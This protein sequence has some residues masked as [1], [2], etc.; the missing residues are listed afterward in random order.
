MDVQDIILY[1]IILYYIIL[2][3]IC[4]YII[5]N[6]MGVIQNYSTRKLPLRNAFA[7]LSHPFAPQQNRDMGL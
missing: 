5:I 7:N 3:M 4:N 1:Y 2:Y 6:Y